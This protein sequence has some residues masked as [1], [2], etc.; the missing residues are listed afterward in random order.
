[1]SCFR[2]TSSTL[3]CS[4]DGLLTYARC[5]DIFSGSRELALN[6]ETDAKANLA[7]FKKFSKVEDLFKQVR[8]RPIFVDVNGD[9]RP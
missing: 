3:K 9:K 2:R 7:T 5:S 8:Y 6:A 1:M 4:A